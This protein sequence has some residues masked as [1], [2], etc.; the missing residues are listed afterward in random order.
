VGTVSLGLS[1][2]L[3]Y[4]LSRITIPAL[5]S[6]PTASHANRSLQEV[7]RRSRQHAFRLANVVN[8]CFLFAYFI[9][10]RR[11]KHPYLLWVSLTSTIGTFGV[12]YW[13]NREQGLQS[14][15]RSTI[16][17]VCVPCL[18][19]KS[20]RHDDLDNP[21]LSSSLL[22][23]TS[24]KRTDGDLIIIENNT[25]STSPTETGSSSS[26]I[27]NG[28]SVERDMERER[29]LQRCRAW[30]SGVALTMGIIGLWGDTA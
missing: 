17:D 1:T 6:M 11:R 24:N 19:A 30:L 8:G 12:D 3:S 20:S 15:L 27:T 28:E 4:S 14:W 16:A 23:S 18:R 9:S 7:K 21:T 26:S 10:S 2:G 5:Q 29:R 22:S 25:P 13:F